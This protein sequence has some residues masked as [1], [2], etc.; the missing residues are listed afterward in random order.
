LVNHLFEFM[1]IIFDTGNVFIL[2]LWHLLQHIKLTLNPKQWSTYL[3][4]NRVGEHFMAFYQMRDFIRHR[5]KAA[6]KCSQSH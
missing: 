6:V 4:G 3:M 5:I 1:D 2:L